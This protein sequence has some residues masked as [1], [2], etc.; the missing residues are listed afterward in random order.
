[1]VTLR[2]YQEE[3]VNATIAFLANN[4]GNPIIDL[5]TGAGKSLVLA[6]LC[7]KL[8]GN[9]LVLSHVQEILEQNLNAL[10]GQE[11]GLW[12]AGLG[13]KSKARITVGG[14]QSVFNSYRVFKDISYIIIDEC[15]MVGQTGRYADLIAKLKVPVIGLTASPYRLKDGYLHKGPIFDSV[16]Y[17]APMQK[18]IEQGYLSPIKTYGAV[19][20]FDTSKLRTVGGDYSI[21]DMALAY[22]RHS[23]TDKIVESLLVYKDTYKHW[24]LFCIDINHAEHVAEALNS[25]GIVAEAVHSESPRDKA[26]EDFKAGKIQAV[27]NVNILT[28]GF[29]FPDIDLIVMLRPTKS[30]VLHVQAVGRGL[31]KAE[32]KT[33]CLVKDFAGNFK[34]LGP[35]DD[36]L[37]PGESNKG[38]GDGT[39]FYKTCPDCEALVAPAVRICSCGYEFPMKHGLSTTAYKE[40]VEEWHNVTGVFYAIHKKS[41][42]PDSLKITYKCGL[43]KT[44]T[45]YVLLEHPGFAGYKAKWWVSQ[46]WGSDMDQPRSTMSLYENSKYLRVPTSILVDESNKYPIIKAER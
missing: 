37:V 44:F 14:I 20:E 26:L 19:D 41:G 45:M 9:I 35:I 43:M 7:R 42:K 40:V 17:R 36:V 34:R 3:A 23:V 33:H 18:L 5:P 28:T 8:E 4:K 16:C 29:D 27:A 6:E 15:H 46:H 10:R 21:S 39:M 31:R 30:P 11:V 38:T 25:V 13:I 22:D 12:S 32:G 2:W 24:L 1:M